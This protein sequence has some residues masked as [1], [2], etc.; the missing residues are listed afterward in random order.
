MSDENQVVENTTEVITEDTP[1][2]VENVDVVTQPTE[3]TKE[4]AK[5]QT[6]INKLM[7]KVDGE[8]FEEAL[9]FSVDD[10]PEIVE[11]LKKQLQLA[12]VSQKRMGQHSNLEKEIGAFLAELKENPES[13]LT[14]PNMNIDLDALVQRHL[15]KKIEQSKKT[16]E[17]IEQEKVQARL[18]ELEKQLSER[19]EQIKQKEMQVLQ[20]KLFVEYNTSIEAALKDGG[21]PVNK[22]MK[23]KVAD[24]MKIGLNHGVD[25]KPSDVLALVKKDIQTEL[26]EMFNV[27]PAETIEQFVGKEAVKKFTKQ[28]TPA[29][30]IVTP[31]SATKVVDAGGKKEEGDKKDNK[32][33]LNKF[34]LFRGLG[35]N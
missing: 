21:L 34:P 28:P 18:K 15:E 25:V 26:T 30:K 16:P 19:D 11:Y 9:P 3:I 35:F 12:K 17:Q 24:Y 20:E 27:M 29:K 31:A 7:L 23:G 6:Q 22:Y 8:E 4:Q 13:I 2:V 10:K 1:K 33:S 14:D 32:E 5:I